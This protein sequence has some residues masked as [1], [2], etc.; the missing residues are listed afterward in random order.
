MTLS[1]RKRPFHKYN[2]LCISA[3]L[4][5][6]RCK[7]V[8][9]KEHNDMK[10]LTLHFLSGYVDGVLHNNSLTRPDVSASCGGKCLN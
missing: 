2:L 1:Q 6:D 10:R 9:M 7:G 4:E 5:K 3:E 8:G